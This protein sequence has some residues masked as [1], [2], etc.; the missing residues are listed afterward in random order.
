MDTQARDAGAS[1]LGRTVLTLAVLWLAGVSL[2]IT[3]LA[4]PP[5]IPAIH[6]DLGL[7]E[8]GIGILTS[9]PTFMFALAAIPGSLFIARF[10]ALRTLIAGLLVAAA[11]GAVRGAADSAF[12]LDAATLVMGIGIAVMQPSLPPLVRQWMPTR[13]GFATTIYS[14]GWLVGEIIA[15]WLTIPL[16]LPAVDGNWR[17]SLV[18]WSAPLVLTGVLATVFAP[19]G[20]GKVSSSMSRRR[21]WPDWR[22][23]LLWRL[24]FTLGGA[25]AVYWCSNA[26][27]PDFLTH[28]GRPEMIGA[29]LTALNIGQ[30]PVSLVFLAIIGR[31]AGKSWPLF[32]LAALMLLGTI[33]FI[34]ADGFW[35]VVCAG[36]V[37]GATAGMM[38]LLLTLP[39]ILCAADDVPRMS[40]GIFTISY[41]CS[42]VA[43]VGGGA[44]W[45]ATQSPYPA[46]ALIGISALT[47]MVLPWIGG[48]FR[49]NSALAT[50]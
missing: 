43:S 47:S 29:A 4:V 38:I 10:G 37:G 39:P 11:A 44:L 24:A 41:A 18:V 15:V 22:Q 33:A 17:S 40:A 50:A 2:R 42:V 20:T 3:L 48:G 16:V 34:F 6:R 32:V 13:I 26:F 35:I 49:T 28:A 31:L 5:I 14:N 23:G 8:T 21:W 45:D 9:L 7:D 36:V 30:L 25:N 46:F 12:M 1:G 19:R 27:I